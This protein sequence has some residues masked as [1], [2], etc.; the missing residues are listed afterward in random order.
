MQKKERKEDSV[1][2][3][4]YGSNGPIWYRGLIRDKELTNSIIDSVLMQLDANDIIVGHCSMKKVMEMHDHRI[5]AIDSSIK[6]GKNGNVLFIEKG[7]F[8][9]GTLKGKR[10]KL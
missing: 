5:Y 2:T 1:L 8:F 10:I 6:K 4:I 7:E 9:R 3:V